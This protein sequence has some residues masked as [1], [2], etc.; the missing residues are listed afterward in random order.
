MSPRLDCDRALELSQIQMEY[1][2]ISDLCAILILQKRVAQTEKT[3]G[4]R[5]AHCLRRRLKTRESGNG[6]C[7]RNIAD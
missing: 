4:E 1:R 3:C 6:A 2:Q 7:P 5:I